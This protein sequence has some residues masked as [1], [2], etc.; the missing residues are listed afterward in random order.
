MIT[1]ITENNMDEKYIL[2]KNKMIKY[3]NNLPTVIINIDL[4]TFNYFP[5]VFSRI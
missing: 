3:Y 2:I 4:M 5:F 1:E